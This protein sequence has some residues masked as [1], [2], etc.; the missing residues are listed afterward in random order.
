MGWVKTNFKWLYPGLKVKR[1][2]LLALLGVILSSWGL[3]LILEAKWWTFLFFVGRFLEEQYLSYSSVMIAGILFIILGL[4][5]ISFS[6]KMGAKSILNVVIPY[7]ETRLVE[8]IYEKRQLKRGPKIVAIGGGTGLSVLLRG[9]KQYTSNI[10]AI[11][12]VTDDGGCSGKLRGELGILPPGDLRNN[13]MALADGDSLLEDLFNYRFTK[14]KGLEGRNLGNLLLAAM[15]DLTGDMNKSLKELSKVLA[16]R[17]IVLPSTLS[18]V[19]LKAR[20][21]DGSVVYGETQIVRHPGRIVQIQLVPE[22]CEPVEDTL[23]AIEEAD[24]VIIGPGSLYTS[25]IPNLLIKKIAEAVT[26]SSSQV[27]YVCNVMTQP[28]ETDFY[29]AADHLKAIKAN[30]P[31]LRID[32]IIVNTGSI[33]KSHAEKYRLKGAY[34][35]ILDEKTLKQSGVKIY[36]ADLVNLSDLVRHDSDKL[37]RVIM[38]E[39]LKDIPATERLKILD[40]LF[41]ERYKDLIS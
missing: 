25:V 4:F 19:T 3:A 11:V 41:G 33:P 31:H 21:D 15:T 23:K 18:N 2:L 29:T 26:K 32:K 40:L 17:G 10:T 7:N 36:K 6:L 27:Y 5:T 39:I 12:T 35:V 1:W 28:G 13:L 22:N 9:L 34:P 8:I 37:A 38:K 20:M 16:V 24:A 14:G 30:V